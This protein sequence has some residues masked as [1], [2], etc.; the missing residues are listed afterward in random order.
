M[1]KN[2]YQSF[3]NNVKLSFCIPTY[4]RSEYLRQ[5]I[6][7]IIS[8]SRRNPGC[9]IEICVSDNA[10]TDDTLEMIHKLQLVSS[11]VTILYSRV[12]VN[13][14]PDK[15][16]LRA[17]S[18]ASG[19]FCWLFGSDDTLP[20]GS[21]GVV[22]QTLH[23]N[24]VDICVVN[25][26]NC[27]KEMN[28]L[29]CGYWLDPVQGTRT[30]DTAIDQDLLAYLSS[31]QSL[32][33]VFSYLSSIIVSRKRWNSV[34]FDEAFIGTA[35]SHAYILL[36]VVNEGARLKYMADHLVNSRGGND[37]FAIEGLLKRYLLDYRG[38]LALVNSIFVNRDNWRDAVLMILRKEHRGRRFY[39]IRALAQREHLWPEVRD[40]MRRCGHTDNE[41]DKTNWA[42]W[43]AIPLL[44]L[45][46]IRELLRVNFR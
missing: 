20:E 33:A 39:K 43:L 30:Y 42:G 38:Y 21:M 46:K 36:N 9:K 35:Y 6:E 24:E 10:S 31:A 17:V 19:D 40:L 18:M 14:G 34:D 28:F 12:A 7:S 25:R 5:S 13:A 22:L 23:N 45:F 1:N 8:E 16:Y 15:N 4:N 11:P 32:G 27:D 3:G 26:R 2:G 37:S 29:D 41:L 44:T